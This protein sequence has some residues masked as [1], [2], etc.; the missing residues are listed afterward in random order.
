MFS[1]IDDWHRS[2][3][4]QLE[5]LPED[6]RWESELMI[7]VFAVFYFLPFDNKLCPNSHV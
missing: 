6:G 1:S 7:P 5:C 4:E 3:F 2:G